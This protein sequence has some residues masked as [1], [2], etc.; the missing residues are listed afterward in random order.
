VALIRASAKLCRCCLVCISCNTRCS[1]R[2]LSCRIEAT[3]TG[4]PVREAEG[5]VDDAIAAFRYCAG[6]AE[7]GRTRAIQT[8]ASALPDPSFG[9]TCSLRYVL[10]VRI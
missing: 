4:K 7:S 10:L 8:D 9:G 6:L 1:R 3:N 5:D 2:F